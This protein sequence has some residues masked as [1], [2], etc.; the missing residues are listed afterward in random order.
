[1]NIETYLRCGKEHAI[2]REKL[3]EATGLS[4]RENR[5]LISDARKRGVPIISTS[6]SKGYYIAQNEAEKEII[7]REL[8]CKATDMLHAYWS[9]RWGKQIE[10][11]MD[12]DRFQ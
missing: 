10:G 7:L 2:T 3:V 11:Q 5:K 1:M 9:I 4:D 8:M 6:R 12:I